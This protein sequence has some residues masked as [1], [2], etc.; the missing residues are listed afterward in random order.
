VVNQWADEGL[1]VARPLAPPRVIDGATWFIM[2]WMDGRQLHDRP[3]READDERLGELLAELHAATAGL[4][5]PAQRPGWGDY[6]D[7]AYPLAGGAARRTE[8]LAAAARLDRVV[9]DKFARAAD[10]LEA[11]E[12]PRVFASYPRHTIHADFAPWNVRLRQG[13]LTGLLDF[14]LAHIGLRAADI[15]QSRRGAQDGVVRGYLRRASLT[16]AELANLDAFWLASL[17]VGVWRG[18]EQQLAKGPL[19][20]V[21]FPWTLSHLDIIRPYGAVSL[22]P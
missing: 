15:A 4:P 8:L 3:R 19:T 11:R 10:A 2:P 12:L 16:E 21:S 6:C 17:M 18:L 14:E 5:A 1:P 9:A 22:K 20:D 7:G 13:K